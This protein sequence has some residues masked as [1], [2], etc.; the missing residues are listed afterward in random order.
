[1]ALASSRSNFGGRCLPL[2]RT[3]D[4]SRD[5]QTPLR[6]PRT[7]AHVDMKLSDFSPICLM[8]SLPRR[9]AVYWHFGVDPLGI[10]RAVVVNVRGG[11]FPRS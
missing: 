6:Q 11:G 7:T 1:M 5:G 8:L 3:G 9:T 10:L 2:S 4:Y